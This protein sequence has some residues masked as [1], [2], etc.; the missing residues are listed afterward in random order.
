MKCGARATIENVAGTDTFEACSP[1]FPSVRSVPVFLLLF[2]FL[3]VGSCST[4]ART[5]GHTEDTPRVYREALWVSTDEITSSF[6]RER[7]IEYAVE[8]NVN[9]IYLE[10]TWSGQSGCL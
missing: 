6:R 2:V 7:L 8:N 3:L 9:T 5:V 4:P 10:I 1:H